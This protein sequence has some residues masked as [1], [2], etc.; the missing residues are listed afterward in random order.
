MPLNTRQLEEIVRGPLSAQLTTVE[1][2]ALDVEEDVDHDGDPILRIKV[3]FKDD[4]AALDAREVKGLIRHLRTALAEV[5]E[6]R[7][8]VLSFRIENELDG[9]T[10][11]AA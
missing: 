2:V 3:M 4:G 11:E 1:I 5:D 8:P 6:A 7:F 10:S 9:E